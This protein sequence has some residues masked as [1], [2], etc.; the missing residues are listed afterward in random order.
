MG[1][2]VDGSSKF[3]GFNGKPLPV[4][5]S[6]Q[7]YNESDVS[8]SQSG[9]TDV[10][11][12]VEVSNGLRYENSIST[13]FDKDGVHFTIHTSPK[14]HGN[15]IF[16]VSAEKYVGRYQTS[17]FRYEDGDRAAAESKVQIQTKDR[18]RAKEVHADVVDKLK[19]GKSIHETLKLLASN[20]KFKDLNVSYHIEPTEGELRKSR[21]AFLPSLLS[22][23]KGAKNFFSSVQTISS[24]EAMQIFKQMAEPEIG[25]TYEFHFLVNYENLDGVDEFESSHPDAPI[26]PYVDTLITSISEDSSLHT[27]AVRFGFQ[28]EA[29]VSLNP[30]DTNAYRVFFNNKDGNI[31]LFVLSARRKLAREIH[32]VLV[33]KLAAQ[34]PHEVFNWLFHESPYAQIKGEGNPL[35]KMRPLLFKM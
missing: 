12:M 10:Y 19:A 4:V 9:T 31:D 7:Y 28:G 32:D 26:P 20:P 30:K 34:K 3:L 14:D 21:S 16:P 2:I 24:L 33:K 17:V 1:M 25:K 13:K 5:T 29:D 27:H 23:L 22:K 18:D 6:K 11:Y 15:S 8:K 35:F